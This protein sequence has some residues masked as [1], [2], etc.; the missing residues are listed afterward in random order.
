MKRFR[1]T[2]RMGLYVVVAILAVN[3]VRLAIPKARAQV[4]SIVPYTVVLA[5][6]MTGPTGQR[7]P[8]PLQTWAG[9][10]DGSIAVRMDLPSSGNR[11]IH[12]AS[13]M[14]VLLNDVARVKSTT[15]RAIEYSWARDLREN[16]ATRITGLP[17]KRSGEP[18]V[19]HVGGYQVA[20][21]KHTDGITLW[22]ALDYGC[23]L[24]KQRMD[25]GSQGASD[26]ELVSLIP[27]EPAAAVFAVPDDYTEGP[28]SSFPAAQ[29]SPKCTGE[30]EKS[31][32]AHLGRADQDYYRHRP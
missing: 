7:K 27:G 20:R 8:G 9:R 6:T 26:L 18:V 31:M 17:L 28:P 3:A 1:T 23:A 14:H 21:I 24:I 2:A 25:F 5:E 4:A 12:F 16:C 15:Q 29:P 13:G 30:C 19:E 32:K 10:S 22:F 11:E